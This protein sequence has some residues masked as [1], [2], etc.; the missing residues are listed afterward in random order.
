MKNLLYISLCFILL[1]FSACKEQKY[2]HSLLVADSLSYICPDSVMWMLNGLKGV[3]QK[4]PEATQKYYQLLCLKA[5]DKSYIRHTSD[6]LILSLLRY[7]EEKGDGQLLPEVYYFAG[8][9]YANLNDTPKALEYYNKA[10]YILNDDEDLRLRELIYT[11]VGHIYIRQDLFHLAK[12]MLL[13]AY[14]CALLRKDSS[15]LVYDMLS[16]GDAYGLLNAM[17]S[18]LYYYQQSFDLSQAM[19]D[20]FFI[21]LSRSQLIGYYTDVDRYD[22]A[23]DLLR[24]SSSNVEIFDKSAT[25]SI[26]AHFY[27]QTGRIDSAAY[28]YTRLLDDGTIYARTDAYWNLS[29][30]ALNRGEVQK[31]RAYLE[32]YR[33]DNDSVN[34]LNEAESVLRVQALYDYS[35]RERDNMRLEV[36]NSEKDFWL[37]CASSLL[38][39]AVLV[40][41]F[42][43]YYNRRMQ[44]LQRDKIRQL[45][46][47]QRLLTPDFLTENKKAEEKLEEQLNTARTSG[48]EQDELQLRRQELYYLRKR[49]EVELERREEARRQL[50]ATGIYAYFKQLCSSND[51]PNVPEEKWNELQRTVNALYQNMTER[52]LQ[53]R[54]LSPYELRICL[55]IKI[56]VS[57]VKM[58]EMTHHSPESISATR[59]R[60]YQ[61]FF[62]E[63]GSPQQWDEF[64]DLL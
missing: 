32:H 46:D 29:E 4:E 64:I 20:S 18:A 6:S 55:L 13:K 54:K 30:I 11:Q 12:E 33:E 56:G 57:P 1:A 60:M 3:M 14:D 8:R 61:K 42:Y 45:Q 19:Q 39:L 51:V 58:G 36:A 43:F 52:L 5:K 35:L 17:D 53:I 41:A 26:L 7:Y 2:P 49:A 38:L 15:V 27:S 62:D 40:F 34:A 47:E 44:R 48:A 22:L 25:Y 24:S 50:Y 23:Y 9:V 28:Y 21:E 63:K 31:A 10:L 59:R 16:V 37:L